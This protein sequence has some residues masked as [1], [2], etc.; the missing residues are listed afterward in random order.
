MATLTLSDE[1]AFLTK[2]AMVAHVLREAIQKVQ[3]A[4]GER[5]VIHEVA[6]QLNVSTI[7]VREA[8]Q[9]LQSEGWV[10]LRPHAGAVATPIS[11][12]DIREIF[13]L[14]EGL[15][16]AAARQAAERCSAAALT[17]LGDLLA[18]MERAASA[19]HETKWSELNVQFH[20]QLPVIAGMPR[21][22]MMLARVSADWE[23][24]RRHRFSKTARPDHAAAAAEHQAMIAALGD[25]DAPALEALIR[26]HNRTALAHYLV[27]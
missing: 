1:R 4:P 17:Q 27:G 25:H 12:E 5:I 24:L 23:R 3:I 19:G 15:E 16:L 9:L 6:K 20:A 22:A 8:L 18:R 7:P 26:T 11:A 10:E 14:F 2:Q 13:A 21:C